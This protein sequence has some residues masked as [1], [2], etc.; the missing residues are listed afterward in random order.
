MKIRP[1]TK[2]FFLGVIVFAIWGLISFRLYKFLSTPERP[3]Y[4]NTSPNVTPRVDLAL[5]DSL[6]L[7]YDDPFLK[8]KT[9]LPPP[10][11]NLKSTA[12]SARKTEQVLTFDLSHIQ[13]QGTLSNKNSKTQLAFILVKDQEFIAGKDDLVDGFSISEI[14][15][16]SICLVRGNQLYWV[17]KK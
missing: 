7:N 4:S 16:D 12:S 5:N 17:K 9:D 11:I 10:S 13:Y 14:R 15:K 1:S 3:I 8:G 2:P 6:M